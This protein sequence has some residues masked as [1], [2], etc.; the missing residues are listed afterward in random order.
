MIR[1]CT[2]ILLGLALALV[3]G[4]CQGRN[5]QP[6]PAQ[7]AAR[8]AAMTPADAKLADLYVHACKSCHAAPGT[9][10]PQAGD[11]ETWAPRARKGMAAL[12]KSVVTGYKGMPSGGQCFSCT[13]DDYRA[14]IH[15]MADQPVS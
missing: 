8:A 13:T 9:G 4:A 12:M 2:G 7:I 11:R 14:L 15:F 3:L 6:S 5:P 10:A 1:D